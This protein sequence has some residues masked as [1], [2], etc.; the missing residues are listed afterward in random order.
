MN[1]RKAC[2]IDKTLEYI[3]KKWVLTI[4]KDLFLG[5]KKFHEF[6]EANPQL[7]NKVLSQKMKELES[8]GLIEKRIIS[9]T[10]LVAEYYLTTKGAALNRILFEIA[11]YGTTNLKE[12]IQSTSCTPEAVALL[13]KELKI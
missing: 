4:I 1:E 10:P 9:K 13:K 3:G 12:E 11:M 2:P 7:S 5:K 8:H 6:L